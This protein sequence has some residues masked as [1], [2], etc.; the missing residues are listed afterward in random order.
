[1]T[2]ASSRTGTERRRGG[3]AAGQESGDKLELQ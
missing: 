1:M 2:G 3:C